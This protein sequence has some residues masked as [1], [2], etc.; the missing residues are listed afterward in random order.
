MLYEAK[1]K[2]HVIRFYPEVSYLTCQCISFRMILAWL[3]VLPCDPL[4]ASRFEEV[5]EVYPIG[6]GLNF[7]VLPVSAI[8]SASD[9]SVWLLLWLVF[10]DLRAIWPP[11]DLEALPEF[12]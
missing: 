7:A 3:S 1:V 11:L 9:G 8:P 5:A 10:T 12:D 6:S 4:S 2:N